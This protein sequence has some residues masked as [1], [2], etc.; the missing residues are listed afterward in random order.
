[1]RPVSPRRGAPSCTTASVYPLDVNL[2]RVPNTREFGCKVFAVLLVFFF[3]WRIFNALAGIELVEIEGTWYV[4]TT[5]LALACITLIGMLFCRPHE[6]IRDSIRGLTLFVS[7]VGLIGHSSIM[8]NLIYTTTYGS[9]GEAIFVGMICGFVDFAAPMFLQVMFHTPLLLN[10]FWL[11]AINAVSMGAVVARYG[12]DGR[13]MA[14]QALL[15]I[16][17]GFALCVMERAARKSFLRQI[18]NVQ[19]QCEKAVLETAR[20]GEVGGECLYTH[21]S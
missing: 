15:A 11:I 6:K 9:V 3:F 7:I 4:A 1:M 21:P 18:R 16:F 13:L 10:L 2:Q 5:T 20:R 8:M 14:T 19:L 17:V 12:I